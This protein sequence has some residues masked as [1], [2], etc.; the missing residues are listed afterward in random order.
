M[1]SWR[2]A[3]RALRPRRCVCRLYLWTGS[4]V[5]DRSRELNLR[6]AQR[7][8]RRLQYT[9]ELPRGVCGDDASRKVAVERRNRAAEWQAGD[10]LRTPLDRAHAAMYRD[11]AVAQPRVRRS[12]FAGA[13]LEN[14]AAD[15]WD[16]TPSF[17][18]GNNEPSVTPF[19]TSV[20][21]A[22]LP[23]P[24]KSASHR[25]GIGCKLK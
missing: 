6:A 12:A 17:A 18:G 13:R 3:V 22:G 5:R 4:G 7:P 20:R 9:L 2:G 24:I 21:V 16:T 1:V 23:F 19:R 10:S 11:N 14:E 25:F 8:V 15:N